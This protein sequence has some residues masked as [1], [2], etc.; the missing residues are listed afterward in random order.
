MATLA[1]LHTEDHFACE[2]HLQSLIVAAETANTT[3][4]LRSFDDFRDALLPHLAM[5]ENSL[6]NAITAAMPSAE[7]TVA[8]LRKAHDQLRHQVDQAAKYLSRHDFSA[9][10]VSAR[11]IQQDLHE[12]AAEE[13]RL[14]TAVGDVIHATQ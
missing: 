8:K 5:E 7:G 9:L 1:Q 10:A 14:F 12:H 4:C 11:Q 13:E 3:S 6:F 2:R